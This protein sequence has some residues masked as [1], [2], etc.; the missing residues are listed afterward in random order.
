M[1]AQKGA[2]EPAIAGLVLRV[3]GAGL[4]SATLQVR[5]AG[6]RLAGGLCPPR[7]GRAVGQQDESGFDKAGGH[8]QLLGRPGK[9][10]SATA[11]LRYP[12][13]RVRTSA[14]SG[15]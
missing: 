7:W 12:V 8:G 3:L 6:Q 4:A 1:P 15:N 9:Q 14:E 13:A 10:S 5:G 2:D 11:A